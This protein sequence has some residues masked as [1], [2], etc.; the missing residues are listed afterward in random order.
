MTTKKKR[1]NISVSKEL[2]EALAKLAKR[3]EMPQ[4]TKAASLIEQAIESEEDVV[5]DKIAFEREKRGVFV[6]HNKA[7][8]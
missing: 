1:I 7:W 4:A 3:D 5:W 6:S 8:K 2:E